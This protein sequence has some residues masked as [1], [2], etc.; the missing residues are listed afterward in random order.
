M[1]K[2]ESKIYDKVKKAV[3]RRYELTSEAYR[4][5]FRTSKRLDDETYAEWSVRL[6]RYLDQWME[7]EDIGLS[8]KEKTETNKLKDLFIREQLLE[9]SPSELRTWLKEPK[10]KSVK[11]M[12]E[13]GDQYIVSRSQGASENRNK[14]GS[15]NVPVTGKQTIKK[16]DRRCYKCNKR[17]HIA[18]QCR[19]QIA[20]PKKGFL[21]RYEAHKELDP[22]LSGFREKGMVNG[23]EVMMLRDT[24]CTKILVHSSLV[25]KRSIIPDKWIDICL[26][27][28]SSKRLPVAKIHMNVKD[29]SGYLEVGVL[30]IL[31]EN[32]LLGN[33]INHEFSKA[34]VTTRAQTKENSKKKQKVFK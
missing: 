33:D 29:K 12:V 28:G 19:S 3:L 22:E 31:P 20:K 8:P 7:A 14:F 6:T 4:K 15:T 17:G 5:K 32:V 30:D 24:G 21:S 26:A 27:D 23:Q 18:A 25:T 1:D 13:L 10:P 11:E 2:D 34:F 9:S 16:E